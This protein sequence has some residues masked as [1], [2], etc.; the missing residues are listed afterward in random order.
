M[1]TVID[2]LEDDGVTL[3][4]RRLLRGFFHRRLFESSD[5]FRRI[6]VNDI[7]S[8]IEVDHHHADELFKKI[9]LF[10]G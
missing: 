2:K 10:Y 6:I 8:F 3:I 9:R 7:A 1:N 5:C 4:N